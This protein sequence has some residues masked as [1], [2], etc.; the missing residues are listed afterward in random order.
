MH[1]FIIIYRKRT[2]VMKCGGLTRTHTYMYI[3]IFAF[4]VN[5]IF[6]LNWAHIGHEVGRSRLAEHDTHE[7]ERDVEGAV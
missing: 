4:G 1:I 5:P 7:R 3:Y 6:E 2:L